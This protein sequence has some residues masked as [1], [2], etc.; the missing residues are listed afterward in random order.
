MPP[1][2]YEYFEFNSYWWLNIHNHGWDSNNLED[3][4]KIDREICKRFKEIY[5]I[6]LAATSTEI[7]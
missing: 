2:N 7:K 5:A 4:R 3:M 6:I 1:T